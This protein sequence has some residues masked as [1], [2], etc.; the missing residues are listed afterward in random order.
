MKGYTPLQR[1]ELCIIV[2]LARRGESSRAIARE[3]S[4]ARSTVSNAWARMRRLA[5]QFASTQVPTAAQLA[6]ALMADRRAARARS[7][8]NAERWS[9]TDPVFAELCPRLLNQHS[10]AQAVGGL[11]HD[12]EAYG[13]SPKLPSRSTL[14]R[15]AKPLG[16][17]NRTR[18]PGI[19][20]RRYA[21]RAQKAID[22]RRA[23]NA[24]VLDCKRVE[25]RPAALTERTTSLYMEIDSLGS[26]KG[27]RKRLVV[28]TCRHTRYT[29]IG[30]LKNTRAQSVLDWV[31]ERMRAQQLPLIA[32]IP[33][34]GVEFSQLPKLKGVTI[35]PCQPHRPWQKPT[36]ENTNGLIRFY[37][38]K[39][40][41]IGNVTPE[42]V[43][44]VEHQLNHRPRECLNWKT[45]TQLLSQLHPAARL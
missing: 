43:A 24:W 29:L 21:Q 45:P 1:A 6:D 20:L 26:P 36:V 12:I 42:F 38:P 40:K 39:G 41:L 32:L 31:K 14:Y 2:T 23:P 13:P 3:L 34:Q 18:Y 30:W 35:Y 9:L 19:R 33:D 10:L 15:V 27:D 5:A 44:H 7:A 37:I 17:R 25:E 8:K 28:A 11:R 22:Q 16:W 4:R